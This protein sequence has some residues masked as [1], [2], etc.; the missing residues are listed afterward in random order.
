MAIE[1]DEAIRIA[2]TRVIAEGR[3]CDLANRTVA[4]QDSGEVWSVG[5]FPPQGHRGRGPNIS[6]LKAD[7]SILDIYYSA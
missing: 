3:A 4:V 7:G 1:K 6:V 5:W 2:K